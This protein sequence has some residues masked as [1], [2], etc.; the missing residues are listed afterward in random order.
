M[1]GWVTPPLT[2]A[3]TFLYPDIGQEVVHE[4]E[5]ARREW[6]RRGRARAMSVAAL[7]K[8]RTNVAKNIMAIVHRT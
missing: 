6:E 7:N 4:V 5:K 2:A 1:L 8:L 3:E